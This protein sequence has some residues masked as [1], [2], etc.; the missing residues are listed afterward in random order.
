MA[1]IY[2]PMAGLFKG[3]ANEELNQF[4]EQ[5]KDYIRYMAAV[6]VRQA[7]YVAPG[8]SRCLLVG[9]A[10]LPHRGPRAVP[11]SVP[12]CA[13][14]A[15]EGQ[16]RAGPGP[17]EDP[18]GAAGCAFFRPTTPHA[19]TR[20]TDYVQ[21]EK[22]EMQRKDTFDQTTRTTRQELEV[23]EATKTKEIKVRNHLTV[24]SGVLIPIVCRPR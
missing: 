10:A 19:H 2:A 20:S 15:R 5:L 6:K 3:V 18:E 8:S 16:D 13:R 17:S 12:C 7:R 21:D 9:H 22:V 23:F 14:E 4:E 24:H 11:G 1:D